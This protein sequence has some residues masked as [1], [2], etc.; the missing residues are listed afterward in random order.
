MNKAGIKFDG[1]TL[2]IPKMVKLATFFDPDEHPLM[3]A[4][5]L[6]KA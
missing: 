5:D 1:E 6:T 3:I 2:E 4:E